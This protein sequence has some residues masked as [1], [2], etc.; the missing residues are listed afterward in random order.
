MMDVKT[1]PKVDV[2]TMMDVRTVIWAPETLTCIFDVH[3]LLFSF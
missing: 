1:V 3:A 2:F